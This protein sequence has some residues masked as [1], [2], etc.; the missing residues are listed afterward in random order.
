MHVQ[1]EQPE[2]S[3][4]DN[5]RIVGMCVGM[6]LG[7]GGLAYASVPLYELFCQVTGFGGTTQVAENVDGIEI[8]DRDVRVRFDA[9]TEAKLDWDFKPEERHVDLK[10]GEKMG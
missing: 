10:M 6:V 3:N 8:I 9:N 4:K 5:I 7:M 2:V 1:N